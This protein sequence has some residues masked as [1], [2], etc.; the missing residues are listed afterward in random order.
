MLVRARPHIEYG[1]LFSILNSD[2]ENENESIEQ[3]EKSFGDVIGTERCFSMHQGRDAFEIALKSI[4]VSEGDEIIV[5]N[6]ICFV[7]IDIILKL[8]A[9]PVLVDHSLKDFNLSIDDI[10]KKITA[11]TK[12]LV[13]AHLYGVPIDFERLENITK[14]R[15]IYIIEDCAH[16]ISAKYKNN[17]I[18]QFG[19][20]AFF[21]FNFDKPMSTG[22]GGMLVVN[23]TSL[24]DAVKEQLST[25]RKSSK[26]DEKKIINSFLLQ[27][28]LTDENNYKEYLPID[29][30]Y[31]IFCSY[32][33]MLRK[34]QRCVSQGDLGL[35]RPFLKIIK[36][37]KYKVKL[38]RRIRKY[39]PFKNNYQPKRMNAL[40][41][42][43]GLMQLEE[44]QK[45]ENKRIYNS[46][47]YK[48]SLME[49]KSFQIPETRAQQQPSFLR[50]TILNKSQHTRQ[51]IIN[52]GLKDGIE[53]DHSNWT[54]TIS[55]S[56]GKK[57]EMGP[58]TL[59]NS[60]MLADNIIHLPT[61]FY[62]TQEHLEKIV[63]IL[64]RYSN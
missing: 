46:N 25:C 26:K 57:V 11:K 31:E 33:I 51:A 10:E 43:L 24:L 4:G 44:L 7:V 54:Y 48:K 21:S 62:V 29:F 1:S 55:N 56:Y 13:V 61:H 14:D 28:F 45:V 34:F 5:Q 47:F 12:A 19:N 23:D 32:P 18:G 37:A 38:V 63:N 9:I 58:L 50:Y 16:T 52:A 2:I 6:F 60:E 17:N 27:H 36:S 49:L 39:F 64:E 35:I 8:G 41:S 3:F 30:A 42:R 22:L 40:R 59:E 20:L 15:S 53:L